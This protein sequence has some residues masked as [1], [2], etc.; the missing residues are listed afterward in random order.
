MNSILQDQAG[1]KSSKRIAG[2]ATLAL[3]ASMGI[4]LFIF[5]LLRKVEDPATAASVYKTMMLAGGSLLGVG[6]IEMF[7]KKK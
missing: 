7:G 5:S 1:N 6:V 2:F 3:G 4:A